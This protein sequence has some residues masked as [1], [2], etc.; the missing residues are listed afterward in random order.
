MVESPVL[1]TLGDQYRDRPKELPVNHYRIVDPEAKGPIGAIEVIGPPTSQI[2]KQI[3]ARALE[4]CSPDPPD[5]TIHQAIADRL[6]ARR[7]GDKFLRWVV[8]RLHACFE[9]AEGWSFDGDEIQIEQFSADGLVVSFHPVDR[10]T[11]TACVFPSRRLLI[12]A[13]AI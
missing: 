7:M 9:E 10:N 6:V 13:R 12:T 2:A 1:Q 5:E 3:A 8:N 11:G 4:G